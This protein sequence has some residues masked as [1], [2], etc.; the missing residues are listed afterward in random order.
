M[1]EM[2]DDLPAAELIPGVADDPTGRWR[3]R[4]LGWGGS[5]GGRGQDDPG[6]IL[7]LPRRGIAIVLFG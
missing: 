3:M 6:L 1:A 7:I 2:K 5:R 4:S